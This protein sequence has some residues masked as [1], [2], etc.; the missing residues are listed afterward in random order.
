MV[1][2]PWITGG[3]E[4]SEMLTVTANRTAVTQKSCKPHTQIMRRQAPPFPPP[5]ILPFLLLL[6]PLLLL[7]VAAAPCPRQAAFLFSPSLGHDVCACGRAY[8]CASATPGHCLRGSARDVPLAFGPDVEGF[9]PGC[10]D[11]GCLLR[12]TAQSVGSD[13]NARW[14]TAE[15]DLR[16]TFRLVRT[17]D[18][19]TMRDFVD[20]LFEA[21]S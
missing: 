12:S 7:G 18:G 14:Q 6:L 21:V 20:P 11:C 17:T 9:K 1:V 3:V 8:I 15:A 5:A 19:G 10:L 4:S 13:G 2:K 16:G